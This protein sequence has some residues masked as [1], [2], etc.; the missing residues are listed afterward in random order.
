[1]T[2]LALSPSAPTPRPPSRAPKALLVCGL[3]AGPAFMAALLV[4]GAV[5]ADYDPWRHPGSSLAL[6]PWGWVQV[7]NFVV[8]GAL[9][10]AFAA[11]LR[12]SLPVGPG[13]RMGP[14]LVAIWGVGLLGA[15]VFVGDPVS[16]YPRGTPALPAEPSWHG[17]LH[18]WAFSL[19]GFL[20]LTMAMLVMAYAFARRGAGVWALYSGLSAAVFLAFFFLAGAG[21]GQDPELVA[22]AG[23]WQRL[24]VGAGWLWLAALALRQRRQERFSNSGQGT[25]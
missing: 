6:G 25:P 7:V 19:P 1:M 17:L 4:Q 9:T 11:G 10:I 15:G 2:V 21:F 23:L 14:L 3:V 16:G 5:R 20:A 8:A 22:T 12:R 24:G 13:S 18:D